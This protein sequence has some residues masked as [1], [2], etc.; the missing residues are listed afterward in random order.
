FC[1]SRYMRLRFQGIFF[2]AI[3]CQAVRAQTFLTYEIKGIHRTNCFQD[4]LSR[5]LFLARLIDSLQSAGY[6]TSFI[7]SKTFYLD[8]LVAQVE[9][10]GMS[11]PIVLRKGNLD[12]KFLNGY[13]EAFLS[14]RLLNSDDLKT[15]FQGIL[16]KAE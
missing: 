8:T 11:P 6:S 15:I 4:S 5:E 2:L 9:T 16:D 7:H 14:G 12:R 13:Q 10:E 1:F 3:A